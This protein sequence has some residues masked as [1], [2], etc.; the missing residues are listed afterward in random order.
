MKKQWYDITDIDLFV[1]SSRVLVY[2]AFGENDKDQ[3]M[4]EI[5]IKLEELDEQEKEELNRCLPQQECLA[6]AKQYLKK[7]RNKKNEI[8][9]RISDSS[10][11]AFRYDRNSIR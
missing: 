1:E 7:F 11:M 10:Y 9:Y 4:K 3:D 5:K 8:L 6:I 2:A